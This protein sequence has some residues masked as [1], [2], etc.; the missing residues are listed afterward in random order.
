MGC[1]PGDAHTVTVTRAGGDRQERHLEAE[2][3]A[4]PR[5]SVCTVPLSRFGSFALLLLYTG[6]AL[7]FFLFSQLLGLQVKANSMGF[8][9]SFT[10]INLSGPY[11]SSA[12]GQLWSCASAL[13]PGP[14][15]HPREPA[16]SLPHVTSVPNHPRN[17][18][19]HPGGNGSCGAGQARE[20]SSPG[21]AG[22]ALGVTFPVASMSSLPALSTLGT[23]LVLP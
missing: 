10:K 20:L 15:Q 2:A 5:C 8:T 16:S 9:G 23:G 14:R 13:S 4:A 6:L 19:R 7:L 17:P 1:S 18:K 11:S 12:E 21:C 22:Y 3:C